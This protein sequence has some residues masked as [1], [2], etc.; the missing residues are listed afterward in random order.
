ML[1]A[2]G[3]ADELFACTGGWLLETQ[4]PDGSWGQYEGTSEETAYALQALLTLRPAAPALES[5][6][7]RGAAYLAERFD[8]TDYPELW[9]GKG[10][11][12]PYA[13]VRSAIISALRLYQ[14]H[15]GARR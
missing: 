15:R 13:I 14:L 8:D 5:A 9:I 6:L 7:A 1:A 4:R 11:Y 10:L 2:Q 12:T 3:I